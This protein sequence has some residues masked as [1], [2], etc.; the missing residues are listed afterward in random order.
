[1]KSQFRY[2]DIFRSSKLFLCGKKSMYEGSLRLILSI[3]YW[4]YEECKVM[5]YWNVDYSLL[6]FDHEINFEI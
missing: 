5:K 3:L 1:M 6:W 2:V 4:S